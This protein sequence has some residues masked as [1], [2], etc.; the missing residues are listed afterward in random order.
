M[1]VPFRAIIEVLN[2]TLTSFADE[3]VSFEN[4]WCV[5]CQSIGAGLPSMDVA[6]QRQKLASF[7]QN[8]ALEKMSSA[9]NVCQ[10]TSDFYGRERHCRQTRRSRRHLLADVQPG[11]MAMVQ[12]DCW[13]RR[14]IAGFHNSGGRETAGCAWP[15]TA[16]RTHL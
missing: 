4:A 3:M 12:F 7:R 15:P 6:P 16:P 5:P 2:M 11:R 10:V 8:A 1:C 13:R 14:M 9:A